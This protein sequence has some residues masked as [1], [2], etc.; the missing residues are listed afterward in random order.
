MSTLVRTGKISRFFKVL[1]E[2]FR[3]QVLLALAEGEACVCHLE[4]LLG[5]RQ[6]YISQHLMALRQAGILQTRREGKYVFY[7][8]K[9]RATLELVHH[10]SQLTGLAKPAVDKDR[11]RRKRLDCDCP[12]C[13][14][15]KAI[16]TGG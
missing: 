15:A 7:G 16:S 4:R 11:V 2:P 10:A 5:K 1:G 14:D 6:A 13:G 3:V 12:S 9:D 8:L